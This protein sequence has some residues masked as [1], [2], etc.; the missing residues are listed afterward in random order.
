LLSVSDPIW[1]AC[2]TWKIGAARLAQRHAKS[3]HKSP[4]L[5]GKLPEEVGG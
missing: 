4:V 1:A 2:P 3:L 5:D